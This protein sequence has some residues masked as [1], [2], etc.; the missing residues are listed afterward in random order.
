[1][2]LT[3]VARVCASMCT[4]F[5]VVDQSTSGCSCLGT[6]T[7]FHDKTSR[8]C[9]SDVIFQT[10]LALPP[11]AP[12]SSLVFIPGAWHS[13]NGNVLT[14]LNGSRVEAHA[15]WI[16]QDRPYYMYFDKLGGVHGSGVDGPIPE[17]VMLYIPTLHTDYQETTSRQI[18]VNDTTSL[19]T[20]EF[21]RGTVAMGGR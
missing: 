16:G 3:S 20:R 18:S 17:T 15:K 1:M 8:V 7:G 9:A 2:G 12:A 6:A 21:T 13:R 5:F 10:R 14:T 19:F 4:A 11:A